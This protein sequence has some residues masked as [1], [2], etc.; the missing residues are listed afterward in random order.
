MIHLKDTW[1]KNIK[2]TNTMNNVFVGFVENYTDRL[3]DPE[4]KDNIVLRI[5]HKPYIFYEDEIKNIEILS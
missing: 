5:N 1:G 4:E 3:N 2:L